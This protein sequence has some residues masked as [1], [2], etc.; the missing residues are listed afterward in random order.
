[1]KKD[2]LLV[3]IILVG[4]S[5]AALVTHWSDAQPRNTAAQFAE[6]PLY[7]NGAAMKRLTLAF[8]G[9]ASDWYWIRSLQYV[10]RKIVTF[11]DS[12]DGRFNL[13]DLSVLD[14]RA[15]PALLRMSTTLDPQFMEPYYYGAVI[16][17]DIDPAAAISLLHQGIA[18]NPNQWRLYQHLGYIYWQRRDYEKASEV[19][20]AGARLPGAPLWMTAISAR[21]K[22]EGGSRGAAREMYRHLREVSNDEAVKDMVAKQITRLDSLDERDLISDA[23]REY[24]AVSGR[25]A[26]SWREVASTLRARGLRS[27]S[28]GAPLDPTGTPYRLTKNGC[29][30]DLDEKSAVP[31]S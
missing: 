2:Y 16:L 13:N 29:E 23:L 19:Y 9:V 3:L 18:A 7:L 12:H 6:E 31:K 26:S 28:S 15:L 25:C 20:A 22:A 21:M 10:G 14:L 27:D 24:G 5:A 11:E 4:L 30:V 1:M 8:N 17:P